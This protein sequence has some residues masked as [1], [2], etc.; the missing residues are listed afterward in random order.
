M[1]NLCYICE[2]AETKV[3]S[4][5]GGH[6]ARKRKHCATVMLAVAHYVA[7]QQG[8]PMLPRITELELV[9]RPQF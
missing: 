5:V 4:Y 3:Y 7:Q 6:V 8:D 2:H 1:I 9:S